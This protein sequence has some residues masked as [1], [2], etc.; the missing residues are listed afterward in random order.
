MIRLYILKYFGLNIDRLINWARFHNISVGVFDCLDSLPQSNGFGIYI[1]DDLY[2]EPQL[3]I[4]LIEGKHHLYQDIKL[5]G[6]K[7]NPSF[8]I[9][10]NN[11]ENLEYT[12]KGLPSEEMRYV[13][14][15]A[16]E[17]PKEEHNRNC[18]KP[19]TEQQRCD[20]LWL[21]VHDYWY[22][23]NNHRV[24]IHY[25]SHLWINACQIYLLNTGSVY[26]ELADR[27]RSQSVFTSAVKRSS[28]GEFDDI[29]K[30]LKYLR[31]GIDLYEAM[32]DDIS[33]YTVKVPVSRHLISRHVLS[34]NGRVLI[35]P[36]ITE[37][38]FDNS[39]TVISF[40]Y[41]LGYSEKPNGEYLES[42]QKFVKI[43]HPLVFYGD[44]KT[45]ELV[46]T[47]RK[48][49]PEYT[50][51]I[52]FPL[53]EWELIQRYPTEFSDMST[54][55]GFK[56]SKKYSILTCSKF[57]AIEH[58]I[59]LNPFLTEKFAWLDSGVFRHSHIARDE[60]I[61]KSLF[62]N[63]QFNPERVM[64]PCNNICPGTSDE[65]FDFG[66]EN[67]IAIAMLGTPEGW[68]NFISKF[69]DLVKLKFDQGK[70]FTEQVVMSRLF[71][72]YPELIDPKLYGFN[73]SQFENMLNLDME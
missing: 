58:A 36:L 52:A 12:L 33:G 10:T 48:D 60:I 26:N 2:P 51:V 50:K 25:Y 3:I 63:T 20:L 32:N 56:K 35:E 7:L 23:L 49:Y 13:P 70:F 66:V 43:S 59:N 40:Y 71:G 55:G 39:T 11:L 34:M 69:K 44:S 54:S 42:I 47:L 65:E 9:V 62:R 1:T 6:T 30:S 16:L 67:V 41:D 24:V 68:I 31:E 28:L 46:K 4:N 22:K 61:G 57:W 64:M 38:E 18:G 5:K 8:C 15:L 19:M 72:L 29:R 37:D 45:C 53:S 17:E 21:M 27:M 73:A 14:N